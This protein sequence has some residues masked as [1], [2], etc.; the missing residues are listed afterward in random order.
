MNGYDPNFDTGKVYTIIEASTAY[1]EAFGPVLRALQAKGDSVPFQEYLLRYSREIA[2]PKYLTQGTDSWGMT[3]AFKGTLT[4]HVNI[5]DTWQTTETFGENADDSQLEALKQVLTKEFAIVQG[6][7]GTGKTYIGLQA[8]K[9]MLAN[10]APVPILCVCYTNHALDQFLE[11]IFPFEEDIVRLGG[12]SKSE[13]MLEECS[14]HSE[15]WEMALPSHFYGQR[16]EFTMQLD[17]LKHGIEVIAQKLGAKYADL[18]YMATVFKDHQIDSLSTGPG[19]TVDRSRLVQAWLTDREKPRKIAP[20][21]NNNVNNTNQRVDNGNQEAEVNGEEDDEEQRDE[22]VDED[23]LAEILGE[24]D[25]ELDPNQPIEDD[26]VEWQEADVNEQEIDEFEGQTLDE[27]VQGVAHVTNLWTLDMV[28]RKSIHNKMMKFRRSVLNEQ[29]AMLSQRYYSKCRELKE[30]RN[31]RVMAILREAKV[32]GMTTTAAAKNV[33]LLRALKPKIVIVEEAAE[34]LE[35]HIITALTKDTEHLI[36]IGD[37]Q[38]LR[39]STAVYALSKKYNLDVSLFERMTKNDV[40]FKRL[41]TQRRMR[42]EISKLISSLYPQLTDHPSVLTHPQQVIGISKN[43]FF[44]DHK[45]F[46]STS[47]ETT[48]RFNEHE[49]MLVANLCLY[50]VQQGYNPEKVTVLTM[51]I[52]HLFRVKEQLRQNAEANPGTLL[53]PLFEL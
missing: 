3:P 15:R 8:A 40:P 51:Y 27:L 30:L 21:N 6:P 22:E 45:V 14:L 53:A 24:R 42:P 52:Q 50:L 29:M 36:L 47:A 2:P 37:H 48:S 18:E 4:R 39:P 1:F 9:L 35:A 26:V 44:I 25:A 34:V 38:Q 23:E 20:A 16:K 17:D 10:N 41:S 7:P 32:I 11:G 28:V 5:L 43:L 49:V 12:R 46:E 19:A 31:T 13:L 33:D